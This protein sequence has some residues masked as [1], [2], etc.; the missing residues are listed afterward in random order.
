M[1]QEIQIV[2]PNDYSAITL[3]QYLALQRDLKAYEGDK[4]AITATLFYHLCGVTPDI[5]RKIDTQTFTQISDRLFS[6]ISQNEFDLKRFVTIK[7]V[8]YG[9]EPDLSKMAYGAYVDISKYEKL[10]I[11]EDWKKIMAILYRP[12]SKKIGKLYEIEPYTGK[13][14]VEHWNDVN[15]EVHFGALFFFINLS[16]DLLNTTLKSLIQEEEI[17]Q[18]IKS[19]LVESGEIISRL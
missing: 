1:K 7:G 14:E 16:K 9:F 2:T 12:V 3:K 13:E 8:E 6:F 15:M 18:N 19:I 4:E 17:P 5:L 11:D 10:D